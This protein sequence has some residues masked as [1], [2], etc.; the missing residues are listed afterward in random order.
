MRMNDATM[1]IAEVAVEPMAQGEDHTTIVESTI[2]ALGQGDVRVERG[3]MST[4]VHGPLHEVL[5]LVGEA[6][7]TARTR[8]ERVVTEIRLESTHDGG[9]FEHRLTGEGQPQ[10]RTATP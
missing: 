2:A 3:P 5:R 8:C 1:V 9:G 7:E 4:V 10:M 6:H